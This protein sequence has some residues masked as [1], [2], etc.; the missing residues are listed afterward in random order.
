MERKVSFQTYSPMNKPP[1]KE[2]VSEKPSPIKRELHSATRDIIHFK[3]GIKIAES[4]KA[5]AELE[6]SGAKKTV[7]DL[8]SRIEES[9]SRVKKIEELEKQKRRKQ[10]LGS[11]SQRKTEDDQ[12]AQVIRQL[13]YI[14]KDLIKLKL[15]MASVLEETRQAEKE[16]EASS[17][18]IQSYSSSVE[19]F[20]KEIDEL[21]EEHVLVEL[22]RIEALKE[23]GAIEAQRK[24]EAKQYSSA[25][26]GTR[27]KVN[28]LL[29][30]IDR[31]REI[32]TK[33]AAT[34]DDVNM[35]KNELA[36]LKAMDIQRKESLKQPG[37]SS[38]KGEESKSLSFLHSVLEELEA[39]KKELA[40][41]NEEGFQFMAS[42]DIV[43]D[44][45][46]HLVQEIARLR[47]TEEKADLAI[48]SLNSKLL[49]AKS[50]LE[51][52]SAA[53]EKANSISSSLAGTLVQLKTEAEAAKKERVI[54][55]EETAKI[56]A[57]VPK[58]ESEMDLA[59]AKLESSI[60]ELT[61]VKSS[62]SMALE[63]LKTL[64]ENSMRARASTSQTRSTITIS[65]FEYEYLKGRA[66]RAE[67]VADKKVV[68]AQAWIEAVKAS[69]KEI[70]MKTEITQKEIREL[71]VEEEHKVRQTEQPISAKRVVE[72]EVWNLGKKRDKILEPE[73]F[74][75]EVASSRKIINRNGISTPARRPKFRKSASPAGWN[76][77]RSTSIKV[78]R[79]RKGVPNLA[80]FFSSKNIQ[81][82]H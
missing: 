40:A 21:N 44:E 45:F 49:R 48:Q 58:I 4:A 36:I 73:K 62:E 46:K 53:E 19:T 2:D 55:T 15:D 11:S 22:A 34:T 56:K 3:D 42:M 75:F 63:N 24:E 43:R 81:R 23:Y 14:K 79:R 1:L 57:E 38:M 60:E 28:Y 13:E 10:V 50:K 8:A 69:E 74:Q 27:K 51:A 52:V 32:E 18:K 29:E 7:K 16:V 54:I 31:T 59:E 76:L 33:L 71:R 5:R 68:A 66:A 61:A 65:T 17:S 82:A 39:A 80:K 47:K 37:D 78:N 12:Y 20:R 72:D 30:E 41:I 64:V 26:E 25:L 77:S 9:N 70:L 67:E 6:L 35:L